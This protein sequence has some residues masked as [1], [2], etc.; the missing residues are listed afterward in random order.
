MSLPVNLP[1]DLP[2][3]WTQG[4]IVSPNG[5]EVGLTQQHGYNY[6]MRQVNETQEA[7]NSVTKQGIQNL[8]SPLPIANGGTGAI[9]APE[10]IKNLGLSSICTVHQL[11]RILQYKQ[12]SR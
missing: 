11:Y 7:L 8:I 3:N 4:Q 2:E 9:T 12:G 5:S 1:A 10:A 6:L